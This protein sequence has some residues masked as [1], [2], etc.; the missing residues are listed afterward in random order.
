MLKIIPILL[1]IAIGCCPGYHN[2]MYSIEDEF[3]GVWQANNVED[4][5]LRIFPKGDHIYILKFQ[6][7]EN[8][9]EGI[10]YQIDNNI[11][12]IFRYKNVNEQGFI[13]FTLEPNNRLYYTSRNQD[14]S[15]RVKNFYYKTKL[16]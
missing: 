5:I 10:G 9:W 3:V 14:G 15:I 16:P 6:N 2:S 4:A 13:T 11:I 7:G 8:R 1:F 12:A